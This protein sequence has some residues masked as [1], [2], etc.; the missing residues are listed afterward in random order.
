[1]SDLEK[2]YVKRSS[3]TRTA[4]LGANNSILSVFSCAVGVAYTTIMTAPVVL[5]LVRSYVQIRL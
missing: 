4:L 2:H 5:A 1:M 3:C